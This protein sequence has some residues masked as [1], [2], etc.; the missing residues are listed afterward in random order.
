MFNRRVVSTLAALALATAVGAQQFE[1]LP[2]PESPLLVAFK[3]GS[4]FEVRTLENKGLAI[5]YTEMGGSLIS[6]PTQVVDWET[7]M[8]VNEAMVT[9]ARVRFAGSD[10]YTH[11]Q[12]AMA[13]DEA[14]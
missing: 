7:T 12:V 4:W 3:D 10:G 14:V 2:E 9:L 1:K 8:A 13:L 11:S 5:L 6:A